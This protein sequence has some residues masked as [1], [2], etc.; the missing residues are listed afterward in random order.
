MAVRG[1]DSRADGLFER[2]PIVEM[3]PK[4]LHRTSSSFFR[5]NEPL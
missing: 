4:V 2:C 3:Y 1:S 5:D